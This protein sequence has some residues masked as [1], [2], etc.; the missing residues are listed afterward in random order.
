DRSVTPGACSR[1]A[2]APAATC[3]GAPRPRSLT[4]SQQGALARARSVALDRK[5][6]SLLPAGRAVGGVVYLYDPISERGDQRFAFKAVRIE[7]PTG[8][9]L[10]PGPVTVYG[11]GRFIG[12]G[13]TEPVPPHAS[14]VVPFAL[15]RQIVVTK[16]SSDT[17]RIAKLVTAQRGIVTA[18][19]QHR[20]QTTFTVTSRLAEP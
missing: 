11:D 17:D 1:I 2:R 15:D 9:T 10:E 13:I 4:A 6:A 20:R 14:V 8:D 5:H 7:N 18:E 12:E 3:D 16:T 19:V